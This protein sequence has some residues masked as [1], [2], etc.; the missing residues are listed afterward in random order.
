MSKLSRKRDYRRKGADQSQPLSRSI[1]GEHDD[2]KIDWPHDEDF[3]DYKSWLENL[4]CC[5]EDDGDCDR[6]CLKGNAQSMQL[7]RL[8]QREKIRH[9][10]QEFEEPVEKIQL[11]NKMLH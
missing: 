6:S 4:K 10:V 1:D 2:D 9:E 7:V 3:V 5:F 8:I 11:T